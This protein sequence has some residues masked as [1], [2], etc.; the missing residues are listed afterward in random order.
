MGFS[1]LFP[2]IPLSGK[3]MVLFRTDFFCI[4]FMTLSFFITNPWIKIMLSLW[5]K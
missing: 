5:A 2:S 3:K 1:L 4:I